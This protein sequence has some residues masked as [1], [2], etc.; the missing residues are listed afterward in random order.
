[1]SAQSFSWHAKCIW[2]I[3]G[4]HVGI[5]RPIINPMAFINRK[6]KYSLNIQAACDYNYCF[7]HV[8]IKWLGSIHDAR[9]FALSSSNKL[10]KE[11]VI[12]KCSKVIG[13]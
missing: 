10:F 9:S 12:P 3:D 13:P 6:E 8:V 7:F 5:K 11:G 4:T 2:A 1:M